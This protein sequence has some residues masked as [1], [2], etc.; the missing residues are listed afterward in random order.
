MGELGQVKMFRTLR[1][2]M[3]NMK[4]ELHLDDSS[5]SRSLSKFTDLDDSDSLPAVQPRS[6]TLDRTA[7]QG[8]AQWKQPSGSLSGAHWHGTRSRQTQ[9]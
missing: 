7:V 6:L 2:W 1:W 4:L 9:E 8:D 5:E 3:T